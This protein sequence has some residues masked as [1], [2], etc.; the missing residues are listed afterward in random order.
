MS[1]KISNVQKFDRNSNFSNI[2][3]TMISR[4]KN[5]QKLLTKFLSKS[6]Q[7]E[8]NRGKYFLRWKCLYEARDGEETKEGKH[9]HTR[10]CGTLVADRLTAYRR[11]TASLRCVW[12]TP[13]LEEDFRLRACVGRACIRTAPTRSS[14]AR[15]KRRVLL[16]R[17]PP[18]LSFVFSFELFHLSRMPVLAF[19]DGRRSFRFGILCSCFFF[20][21]FF[22]SIFCTLL[23]AQELKFRF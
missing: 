7:R 18:F 3:F 13:T 17:F 4:I 19:S 11:L 20:F 14:S 21:L 1:L 12:L 16:F 15:K 2:S 6:Y 23:R 9:E 10:P 8:K 5:Y 22:N